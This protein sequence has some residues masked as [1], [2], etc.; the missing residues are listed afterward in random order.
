MTLVLSAGLATAALVNLNHSAATKTPQLPSNEPSTSALTL[1]S[2]V[3]QPPPGSP[4]L[5]FGAIV[6]SCMV[7]CLVLSR[8]VRSGGYQPVERKL[9][10]A[11]SSTRRQA[12]ER[13]RQGSHLA[14]ERPQPKASSPD[15]VATSAV[16]TPVSV[17]PVQE[18]HPLDWE[19]PSLADSLDMRQ[20]RPLSHWL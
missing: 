15:S 4:W 17:V 1:P 8:T 2:T 5:S 20:R 12:A 13:D 9:L 7:G 18:N 10:R 14:A 16:A 19:E 11:K 6:L 3:E